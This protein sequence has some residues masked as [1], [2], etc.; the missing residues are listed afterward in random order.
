VRHLREA[1][2]GL[3]DR[4][5]R[6]RTGARSLVAL[7]GVALLLALPASPTTAAPI[8]LVDPAEGEPGDELTVVGRGFEP[9]A[10]YRLLWDGDPTAELARGTADS[11]G[12]FQM[13][14]EIVAG[15]A[16]G[17]HEIW[18]CRT[19]LRRC[20]DPPRVAVIVL[21]PSPT[22]RPTE[23]PAPTSPPP[24]ATAAPTAT[25]SVPSP[26]PVPSAVPS[27]APGGSPPSPAATILPLPSFPAAAVTP[28]PSPLPA[29]VIT[30]APSPPDGLAASPG[31]FPNLAVTAIEVTQ[32]IQDLGNSMPLVAGRRTY[33]RVYVR[34]EGAPELAWVYG[35]LEARRGGVQVGWLWPDNGPITARSF[36]GDRLDLDDSLYY[37]LPL[38]WLEGDVTLRA[39]VYSHDPEYVWSKEPEWQ[40]NFREVAVRFHPATPLTIHLVPLHLHRSYHP[41]DVERIYDPGGGGDDLAPTDLPIQRIAAGLLRFHPIAQL[42]VD[43]YLSQALPLGHASGYE[44]DLGDCDTTATTIYTNH[45]EFADWRPFFEDPSEWEGY[46]GPVEPDYTEVRMLDRTFTVSSF[47]ITSDGTASAWGSTTGPG[48]NPLPGTPAFVDGC[49]PADSRKSEPNETLALHRVWYDWSDEAEFFVGM[50]DP[51]LPTEFGGGLSTWG[52]DAVT[53]RMTDAFGSAN[54]WYHT[55]AE[56]IAHEIGHAVGLSHVPC[57]DDDDDGEPD[58]EAGGPLDESHPV[59]ATFPFCSLAE[60]DP[61]GFYAFD[62]YWQSFGLPGPTVMSN[63]PGQA[64]PNAAFPLMAYQ[65]PGM[66]DPY[67]YCLMLAYYGVPCDP[68]EVVDWD[69][70]DPD[71]G[72]PLTVP[73]APVDAPPATVDAPPAG[74]RLL[75]VTGSVDAQPGAGRAEARW[76]VRVVAAT[77]D[78]TEAQLAQVARQARMED[79]PGGVGSRAARLVVRAGDGSELRS[80]RLAPAAAD[81][82]GS[83]QSFAVT[84]PV[85]AEASLE[86]QDGDGRVVERLTASSRPP[87][88]RELT[89]DAS[90]ASGDAVTVA[91]SAHD[92]DGGSVTAVLLYTADGT[93]WMTVGTGLGTETLRVPTAGLPDGDAPAFRV[94]AFDGWW[95]AEARAA[96]PELAGPRNPPQVRV[97]SPFPA[98]YPTG[99]PIVLSASAFDPEDRRLAGEAIRWTSSIDGELG[100][101]AELVTRS[102]SPGE[103]R[104][105]ASATDS[106]ALVGSVSFAL[107][108]DGAAAAP[109]VPAAL[110]AEVAAILDGS[111]PALEPVEPDGEPAGAQVPWIGLGVLVVLLAAGAASVWIRMHQP[112][113]GG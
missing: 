40:D 16:A 48:P 86:L 5:G 12:F 62:V 58:E 60:V 107:V 53:V 113:A 55:G 57:R 18:A 61:A 85:E 111:V 1:A 34:S 41:D 66:T 97:E 110:E 2:A 106:D 42:N 78:P 8:L 27:A 31:P 93:H 94:V 37:R 39:F 10:G 50:V 38:A 79:P 112:H 80:L 96:V 32:G 21:A 23:T 36:G 84:V 47:S 77:D 49:K 75:L 83:R 74:T 65:G 11:V 7:V 52:T 82:E 98:R 25:S 20:E 19:A 51:S 3:T 103:H 29:V 101:G 4:P 87:I 100:V 92:P 63:S 95:T 35:A 56:T 59:A 22:P 13:R 28:A 72:G 30:P 26:V 14:V 99:A 43:H 6:A 109:P 91:W 70:P 44:W 102:L 54:P 105:T 24:T 67:H 9:G 15:A 81:H 68:A 46:V 89:V 69:P 45:V 33:V 108:V 90:A 73:P 17:S 71:G 104:I 64:A 88:V 76:S